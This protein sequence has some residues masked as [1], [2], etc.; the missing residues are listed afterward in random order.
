MDAAGPGHLICPGRAG[1]LICLGRAGDACVVGVLERVGDALYGAWVYVKLGRRLAHA[2]FSRPP[3]SRGPHDR[4]RDRGRRLS[5]ASCVKN[6]RWQTY[7]AYEGMVWIAPG[8]GPRSAAADD[9]S[10]RGNKE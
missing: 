10:M 9:F 4:A 8:E 2:Q 7:C 5:L 3:P 6:R 1:P